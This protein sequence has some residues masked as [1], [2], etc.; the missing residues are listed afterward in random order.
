MSFGRSDCLLCKEKEEGKRLSQGMVP[1][2]TVDARAGE[3]LDR[4]LRSSIRLLS[5]FPALGVGSILPDLGYADLYGYET[6]MAVIRMI[7]I[8]ACPA[9]VVSMLTI[10]AVLPVIYSFSDPELDQSLFMLVHGIIPEVMLYL[11]KRKDRTGGKYWS[12]ENS[13][14]SSVGMSSTL[15]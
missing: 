13:I 12:S 2:I 6:S 9:S 8:L 15:T 7:H 3:R 4:I 1:I 5:A 14:C 10:E 11:L